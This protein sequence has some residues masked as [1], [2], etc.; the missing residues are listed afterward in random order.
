MGS[1]RNSFSLTK[2]LLC[3]IW[4]STSSKTDERVFQNG[5]CGD[6]SY[7]CFKSVYWDG[8]GLDKSLESD[9]FLGRLW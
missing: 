4:G 6:F 2:K 5:P 7:S 9:S 1:L 8:S 3:A